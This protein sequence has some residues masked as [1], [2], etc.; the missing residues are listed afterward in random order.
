[1]LGW[2]KAYKKTYKIF[3]LIVIIRP[4]PGQLKIW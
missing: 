4:L 3:S 1:M 2:V